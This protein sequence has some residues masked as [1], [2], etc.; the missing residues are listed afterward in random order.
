MRLRGAVALLS[1]IVLAGLSARGAAAQSAAQ[2]NEAWC[3]RTGQAVI[4]A[5]VTV[6]NAAR[7]FDA[8][9]ERDRERDAKIEYLLM[10][11][12]LLTQAVGRHEALVD[13]LES[14]RCGRTVSIRGNRLFS[15]RAKESVAVNT[16]FI[17]Q[18]SRQAQPPRR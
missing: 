1:G 5:A 3:A 2:S 9:R 6:L 7:V 8:E 16:Y 10:V 14:A 17:L 18:Q 4:Q 15:R 13:V 11:N 12:S